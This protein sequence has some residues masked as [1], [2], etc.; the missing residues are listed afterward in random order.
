MTVDELIKALEKMPKDAM[1]YTHWDGELRG[2][3]DIV[4]VARNGA[5]GLYEYGETVYST[6]N[7]PAWAPIEKEDPYWQ[8][9][10]K[11]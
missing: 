4:D 6:E 8:Y 5:V 10:K 2:S 1:V 11:R 3:P 7:R 9:P